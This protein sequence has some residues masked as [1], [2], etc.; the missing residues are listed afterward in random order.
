MANSLG[1]N[2][3]LLLAAQT[4]GGA[5]GAAIGPS[6]IL[7]GAATVGAT[8]REG[9]MLKPLLAVSFAQAAVLGIITWAI[10]AV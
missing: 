2:P 1:G 3:A 8:G 10:S 9:E 5:A 7:L 6:T 4:A